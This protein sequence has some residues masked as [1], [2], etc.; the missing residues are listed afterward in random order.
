MDLIDN[1]GK[2]LNFNILLTNHQILFNIKEVFGWLVVLDLAAL[3]D[4]VSVYIGPSPR[5][6]EKKERK[7]RGEKNVQTTPTHTYCKRNRPLPYYQS[8]CRTPRH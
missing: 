3:S 2:F 7:N 4:S 6:R 5:E 1:Q 8:N